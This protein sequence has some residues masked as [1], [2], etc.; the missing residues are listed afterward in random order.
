MG[1]RSFERGK[2]LW[3]SS[4]SF[5]EIDE[6]QWGRVPSNA[7]GQQWMRM[8][9]AG[10]RASTGPRSFERGRPADGEESTRNR[11]TLQWGRVPLNAEGVLAQDPQYQQ[12]DSKIAS[13]LR[14]FSGQR[15]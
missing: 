3:I 5:D 14:I 15:L 4:S 10:R 7:E 12:L 13:A 6:L 8:T 1:P 9:S 2:V 11:S